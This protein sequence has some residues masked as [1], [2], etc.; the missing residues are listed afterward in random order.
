MHIALPDATVVFSPWVGAS[1]K[2]TLIKPYTEYTRY[3]LIFAK[4]IVDLVLL[5]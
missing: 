1:E 3:T 5:N 4:T 2:Y